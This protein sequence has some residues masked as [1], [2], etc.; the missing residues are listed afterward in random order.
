M[1]RERVASQIKALTQF[2]YLLAGIAKTIETA[3][4]VNL[5]KEDTSVAL[6]DQE[7]AR[8]KAKVKDS[9]RSVRNSRPASATIRSCRPTTPTFQD[10]QGS[11][12]WRRVKPALTVSIKRD[13]H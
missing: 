12:R 5:N 3:E 11:D 4:L 8:N 6:S 10:W 13:S 1:G 9:V 2:V 7:L